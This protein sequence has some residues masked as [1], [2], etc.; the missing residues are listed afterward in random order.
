MTV[1]RLFIELF[2]RKTIP[3]SW[4]GAFPRQSPRLSISQKNVHRAFLEKN[5]R[6]ETVHRLFIE[7][8]PKKTLPLQWQGAFCWWSRRKERLCIF[9]K[10]FIQLFSRKTIVHRLFIELFPRN[11]LPL[12][13]KGAFSSVKS[14]KGSII[15]LSINC[16][17]SFSV[18]KRP[19]IECSSSFSRGKRFFAMKGNNFL[20]EVHEYL[21]LKKLFIVFLREK[22][23]KWHFCYIKWKT[24]IL[25]IYLSFQKLFIKKTQKAFVRRTVRYLNGTKNSHHS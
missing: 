7:L 3:L 19:L 22:L 18:E 4:K 11:T 8:F 15:Y 6:S 9:K 12:Q 21:S 14:T 1:H 17:L 24:N 16:T 20:G 25:S 13:W 23:D 5:D 2:S 10:L